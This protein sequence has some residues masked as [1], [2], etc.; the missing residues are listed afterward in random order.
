VPRVETDRKIVALTF[1]DGPV[2]ESLGEIQAALGT[3][4]ATF[5][6]CGA[7]LQ[8][9][10]SV[11]PKLIAAGHEIGNHTWHHD[12]MWFKSP[13]YIRS[14][15]E[16]TDAAIRAAG[17]RGTI[18]FRAPYGKKLV[19]LP[20]Y[21]AR[22]D[23]IHVTFDV[24]PETYRDVEGHTD[25]IVAHVLERTRPGSI[26]LLHP[27]YRNRKATRA[28]IAPIVAGLRAHGYEFVT[29]SELLA[30]RVRPAINTARNSDNGPA[31]IIATTPF[32]DGEYS[33]SARGIT[34]RPSVS[35]QLSIIVVPIP[36][37]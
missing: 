36:L 5:F 32:H 31:T 14:E 21:L 34:R 37:S 10:P 12:R 3:T 2:A 24:E 30:R 4:K 35:Y 8:N 28:A 20:W 1:D 13:S 6:V 29:V 23:R 16:S 26:I 11:V 7:E 15:I 25:R 22:H 18:L 9:H 19:G 33:R 17:W 27:W